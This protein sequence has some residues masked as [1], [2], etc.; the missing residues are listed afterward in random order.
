MLMCP[1]F[2]ELFVLQTDASDVGLGAA[3]LQK[4][5]G[6]DK[7]VAYASCTLNKTQKNY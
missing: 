5:G 6:E 7:G 3:L 2:T 4:I 1:D